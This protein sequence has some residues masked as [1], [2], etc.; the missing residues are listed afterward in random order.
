MKKKNGVDADAIEVL[1]RLQVPEPP[2]KPE[3]SDPWRSLQSV[4]D[5]LRNVA[6]QL[7]SA[8]M[9]TA[10]CKAAL[11]EAVAA[12]NDLLEK[13]EELEAEAKDLQQQA[14]D[15][16]SGRNSSDQVVDYESIVNQLRSTFQQ[17][18]PEPESERSSLIYRLLFGNPYGPSAPAEGTAPGPEPPKDLHFGVDVVNAAADGSSFGPSK[19]SKGDRTPYA[20]PPLAEAN[21]GSGKGNGDGS[22]NSAAAATGH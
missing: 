16:M 14:I 7:E 22:T 21:V 11:N 19:G 20:K 13:R 1:E 4:K 2:A 17:G 6:V 3:P 12:E 5:K 9:A 18:V 10:D 8:Q 15:S